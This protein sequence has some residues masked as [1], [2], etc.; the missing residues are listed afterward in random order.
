MSK[1]EEQVETPEEETSEEEESTEETETDQPEEDSETENP[2]EESGLQ[3]DDPLKLVES[4]EGLDENQK[5]LLKDS[6]F[7][8]AD[9]TKKTQELARQRRELEAMIAYQ[10]RMSKPQE[11]EPELE[12]PDDPK[13][14][15]KSVYEKSKTDAVQ[16]AMAEMQRQIE[17]ERDIN[18]ASSVDPRL[19]DEKFGK[20]IASLVQA[21]QD[22]QTGNKSLTQATKDALA[23]YDSYA[24]DVMQQT[25]QDITK[26]AMG[27][28]MVSSTRTIP[29][30]TAKRQP[31]N[32][33]EAY[34][35]ALEE[36]GE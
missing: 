23:F 25:K 10:T 11:Q 22:V 9:Y 14:F 4:L 35:Q 26:K 27:K 29:L 32:I 24:K 28:K 21:D 12:I 7:R 13:E 2:Q 16:E 6:V 5:Q 3:T 36:L 18:T 19:N 31:K 33:H 20:L 8:K 34:Q 15:Y 30:T 17:V 1:D